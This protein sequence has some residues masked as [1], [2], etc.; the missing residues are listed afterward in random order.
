MAKIIVPLQGRTQ[1]GMDQFEHGGA[2]IRRWEEP[3]VKLTKPK[4]K[5]LLRD[6]RKN[7]NGAIAPGGGKPNMSTTN[8]L[9]M[10][11]RGRER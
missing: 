9:G 4:K 10:L 5:Q 1:T 2:S 6:R 3:E 7:M 8:W 11:E